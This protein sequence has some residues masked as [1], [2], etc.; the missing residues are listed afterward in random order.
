MTAKL[1]PEDLGFALNDLDR[2]YHEPLGR[3][4]IYLRV[5]T[6]RAVLCGQWTELRFV[7]ICKVVARKS[8]AL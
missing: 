1:E 3:L 6:P 4:G 8:P 2:Y 7:H 5:N